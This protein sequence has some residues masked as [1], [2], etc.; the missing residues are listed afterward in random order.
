V[1]QASVADAG[2]LLTLQ[3]AAYVT[4]ARLYDD[5]EL[6]GLTQSLPELVDELRSAVTLKAVS[7]A[8]SW[9][10]SEPVLMARYCASDG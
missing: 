6:P 7:T 5:P 8:G 9:G 4:E 1:E 2:E 10:R 3:R